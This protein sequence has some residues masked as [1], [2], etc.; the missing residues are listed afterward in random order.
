MA[1]IW[2][3]RPFKIAAA[4]AVVWIT[5]SA[6]WLYLWGHFLVQNAAAI[7]CGYPQ[8]VTPGYRACLA[9]RLAYW[10]PIYWTVYRDY[11]LWIGLPTA[12][13]LVA[14]FVLAQRRRSVKL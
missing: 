8:T 10:H 12:T 11:W 6:G 2:K 9:A 13:I 1:A 3:T 4:L 5:G 7:A 14:G